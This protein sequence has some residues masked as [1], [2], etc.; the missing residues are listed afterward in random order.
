MGTN[1]IRRSLH[2]W[3]LWL[4]V[5]VLLAVVG[6]GAIT[7]P[8]G[9]VAWASS[10][11]SPFT[12]VMDSPFGVVACLGNRYPDPQER[13]LAIER[14]VKAGVR[15]QREE[16]TWVDIEPSRGNLRWDK[17]DRAVEEQIAAGINL[18]GLL[19]YG[20]AWWGD[21]GTD[22]DMYPLSDEQLSEWGAFVRA[23]VRRYG[24]RIRYWEIW[25]EPNVSA[26]WSPQPNAADYVRL[27]R[28][29]HE[30]IAEEA[31][32]SLIVMGGTS[33]TDEIDIDF[34]RQVYDHGGAS[35]FDIL[36]VHPYQTGKPEGN[37]PTSSK[38][39]DLLTDLNTQ[40]PDKP[41]WLTEVGWST[42]DWANWPWAVQ[43]G[44]QAAAERVQA[45][46]LVR[47]YV[48]ALA[49]PG[50]EKVFWYDLRNDDTGDP[51]EDNFGLLQR[52][53]VMKPKQSFLAYQAMTGLLE[54][55]VFQRQVRGP[56][57]DSGSGLGDDV[58][59]YRF[60]GGGENIV[61]LWKSRG[62]STPRAVTVDDVQAPTA[63]LVS[64]NGKR[65][66]ISV[67]NE[68]VTVDLTEEPLYIVFTPGP[69]GAATPQSASSATVLLLDV[70]GS[71]G[72]SWRGGVKIES[73][74]AAAV[75]VIN[76][77]EQESQ[78]GSTS[79]QVGVATFTTD[80]SLDLE[81]T[82]NYTAARR[83][84]NAL[85]PQQDTNIGAGLQVSNQAL[86]SVPAGVQKIIILLSDG[87][88]NE[89]LSPQEILDGP[90][91]E[92]AAAGTCIY[93]VGF[94]DAGNLDEELLESIAIEA[95]CG[96]YNYA[97]APD[98]LER[99]YIRLR[100]RSLGE[101]LGEFQGEVAQDERVTAGQVEVPSGRDALYA[102]LHWPG[103]VLGLVLT[104]PQGQVVD[105]GYPNATVTTYP[106]MVYA[107]VDD[108]LEGT[109]NLGV[110][111]QDVPGGTTSFDAIVSS[112][113]A[114]ATPVP[115]ELPTIT[116]NP[117]AVQSSGGI[118]PALLLLLVVVGAVGLLV[119]ASTR[120]RMRIGTAGA[121]GTAEPHLIVRSGRLAGHQF[122]LGPQ[123]LAIG[124]GR[125]NDV[126]LEE[127]TVSRHHVV[128]RPARG[129]WFL[130]DQGSMAGTF[131]NGRRVSATGLQD[132][133]RIR[134]GSTEF[135]FRV[136]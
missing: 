38:F 16:F 124:R 39:V 8:T 55:A 50:V 110:H 69:A 44:G 43:A 15:W 128:I 1:R 115:T 103:S 97:S 56:T 109:W 116:P 104:D 57:I 100:H 131:V 117:A 49:M 5:A 112:R 26:F 89:G 30:A 108:P 48:Q 130:Q 133:D 60:S 68:Q 102:S 136:G 4:V 119:L 95:A 37:D 107:V 21:V 46:Y 76:M 6:E 93:T 72:E 52:D 73:A 77:I 98:E 20:A 31:P 27:L 53:P 40:F 66:P 86:A 92:A 134:V 74:K 94:G 47:M 22:K 45:S 118:G 123:G 3:R 111:G 80:A 19:D 54:G 105:D 2:R 122:K 9:M 106:R 65:Q 7:R 18:I 34:I 64:L 41:I 33:G 82:A 35:Y 79:H 101:I 135:E 17:Y 51:H 67:V 11:P 42:A 114:A 70:S 113:V 81:M 58:Y 75:D 125:S 90:V 28:A 24:D 78:I 32:G 62:G 13:A 71:M 84:V 59:E 36:A 129:R 88:T 120:E 25:N 127:T 61:V 121:S 132:G 29:S 23:V 99:V 91:Q 126:Q 10:S 85:S 14:M 12:Q 96:E 63:T 83:A 87:L